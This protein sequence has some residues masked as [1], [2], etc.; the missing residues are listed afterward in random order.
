T[1]NPGTGKG[2]VTNREQLILGGESGDGFQV[3]Q[4]QQWIGGSFNPD[5]PG[6]FFDC[7]LKP[8]KLGEINKSE[9]QIGG[10]PPD[11]LKQPKG[12]AVQIVTG[13]HVRTGI[14]QLQR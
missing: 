3:N 11:T 8:G 12:A 4:F 13:N 10:S 1:L 7:V 6:V 5:H 9:I 2:I 14:Q